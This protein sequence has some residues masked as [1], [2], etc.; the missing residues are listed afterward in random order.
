[1]KMQGWRNR[2]KSEKRHK[3]QLSAR[4]A[5]PPTLQNQGGKVLLMLAPIVAKIVR[6]GKSI[7]GISQPF[8][9]F[10]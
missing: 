10:Y 4:A 1:M 3:N 7:F 9:G 8:T 5:A 6:G 2:Q